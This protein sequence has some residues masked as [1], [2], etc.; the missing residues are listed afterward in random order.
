MG[1]W[2]AAPPKGFCEDQQGSTRKQF[3]RIN[4]VTTLPPDTRDPPSG[5]APSSSW[6]RVNVGAS[7]CLGTQ[8]WKS[9]ALRAVFAEKAED[10]GRTDC[11]ACRGSS[12]ESLCIESSKRSKS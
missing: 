11:S 8:T 1:Q 4:K 3:V 12:M 6:S 9:S 7:Y 2:Q 5:L 10:S